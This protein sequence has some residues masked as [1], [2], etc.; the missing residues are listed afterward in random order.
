LRAREHAERWKEYGE[1][2]SRGKV[3]EQ[4]NPRL[5]VLRSRDG[6]KVAQCQ[7]HQRRGN[8]IRGIAAEERFAYEIMRSCLV[9]T[10]TSLDELRKIRGIQDTKEKT[11]SELSSFSGH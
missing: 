1:K 5:G 7:T 9:I 2:Q 3:S 4:I 10:L 6:R 11:I 8:M